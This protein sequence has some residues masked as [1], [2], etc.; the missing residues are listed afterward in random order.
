MFF[1]IELAPKS[2]AVYESGLENVCHEDDENS[3]VGM[4][5]W[6]IVFIL[7]QACS[8]INCST[9]PAAPIESSEIRTIFVNSSSI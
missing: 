2:N 5:A 9:N 6:I 1:L 8:Q 7:G 3:S 4:Q